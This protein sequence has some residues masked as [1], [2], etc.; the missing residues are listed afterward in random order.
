MFLLAK[1]RY[2]IGK[3]MRGLI[4]GF[5]KA[6]CASSFSCRIKEVGSS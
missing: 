6:N 4:G 5:H 2:R 3:R 1:R